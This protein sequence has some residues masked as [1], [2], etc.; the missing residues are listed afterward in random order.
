MRLTGN[1]E[2]PLSDLNRRIYFLLKDLEDIDDQIL[3]GSDAIS[4]SE[5][6]TMEFELLKD[7]EQLYLLQLELLL[8]SMAELGFST[9]QPLS[10]NNDLIQRV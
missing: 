1:S 7:L 3:F 6:E 5:L 9:D 8:K 10:V 4:L 2:M